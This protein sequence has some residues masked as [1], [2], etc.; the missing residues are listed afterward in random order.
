MLTATTGTATIERVEP[1]VVLATNAGIKV[2]A[3]NGHYAT[4]NFTP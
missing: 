2:V 3:I 4:V 1:T